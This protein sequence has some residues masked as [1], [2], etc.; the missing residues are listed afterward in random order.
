MERT[1]K[2]CNQVK[3]T[4]YKDICRNCYQLK[5]IKTIPEKIC[6]VCSETFKTPGLSCCNC[7]DKLRN[8]KSRSISCNSC[9]RIGLL[10]LNKTEKLCTKCVRHKKE[11]LD[12]SKADKRRLQTM[13]SNRRQKGTDINAPKRESKGWW[14]TPEGYILI[15]N[16]THPNSN[17]NGCI[18]QHIFVMSE[19]LKRPIKKGESIHHINGVRDDNRLENL[20]I[21]HRSHPP[22]QRLNEK[23]EWAK[24]FLEEYGYNVKLKL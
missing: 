17:V 14:K 24:N 6:N 8:E 21:W 20:E 9:G 2:V 13:Q 19:H 23:I 7:L 3:N 11:S 16:A 10:I 18:F 15:Y 4:P 1:C 22:G 12:P 5:W